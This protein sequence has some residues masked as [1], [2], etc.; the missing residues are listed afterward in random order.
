MIVFLCL[1]CLFGAIFIVLIPLLLSIM[2]K[3]VAFDLQKSNPNE[4]EAKQRAS[5]AALVA[6]VLIVIIG[7]VYVFSIPWGPFN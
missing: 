2:V 6:F 7:F 3:S 4:T 5:I 1:P